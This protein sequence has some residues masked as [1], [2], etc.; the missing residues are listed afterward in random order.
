MTNA[1]T[2]LA[3]RGIILLEAGMWFPNAFF[4]ALGI[5][6]LAK[7]ANESPVFLIV[8]LNRGIGKLR[9]KWSDTLNSHRRVSPP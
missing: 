5:Y 2:S 3:E 4:L 6:L 7:A 8:W 1:G 9:R